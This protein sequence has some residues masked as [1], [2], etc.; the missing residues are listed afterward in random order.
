MTPPSRAPGPAGGDEERALVTGAS[1]FVGRRLCKAL[2]DAGV[3][4][5]A[6]GRH[7]QDG[8]WDQFHTIDLRAGPFPTDFFD[9]VGTVFHLAGRAHVDT[10]NRTQ[11]DEH[12]LVNLEGTR[13]VVEGAQRA[14]V[15][16]LV[17]LST[18]NA[19]GPPGKFQ[20]D[21]SHDAPPTLAYGRAKRAAEQ[22]VLG[23]ADVMHTVVLRPPLIY[24]PG[25]K[26]NLDRMYQAVRAGRFPPLPDFGDRR[27]LVHAD[28]VAAAAQLAV[29]TPAARGQVFILTD[30][31]A[32]T[33]RRLYRSM[34]ASV[35]RPVRSWALP[36][37]M[38]QAGAAAGDLFL[39]VSHRRA[40]FD[41]PALERL[42]EWAWY[43]SS[44]AERELGWAPGY[45]LEKA[46]L[47]MGG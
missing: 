32:Y 15:P 3:P 41:S 43:D 23:A 22:L 7:P 35:G 26:G 16:R 20:A 2:L 29:R 19:A 38:F 14:G 13:R 46:L 9:G 11:D 21:E 44:K 24:G 5:R 28:D 31:E 12:R 8:P 30:G 40:P 39:R 45:T 17:F 4:V 10:S 25:W 37:V 33:T 47:D 1:G 42:S 27:S 36:K 18:V 6:A 34:A